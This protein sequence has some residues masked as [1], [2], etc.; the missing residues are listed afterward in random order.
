MKFQI[1]EGY[2][3]WIYPPPPPRFP[4]EKSR[5]ILTSTYAR[6]AKAAPSAFPPHKDVRYERA[7]RSDPPRGLS[8][9]FPFCT[10]SGLFTSNK[11]KS[12][13]NRRVIRLGTYGE[14]AFTV[15]FHNVGNNI[16]VQHAF[17]NIVSQRQCVV[18]STAVTV[19]RVPLWTFNERA[20]KTVRMSVPRSVRAGGGRRFTTISG[21]GFT[22]AVCRIV[23]RRPA[24][25]ELHGV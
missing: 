2:I 16:D 25:S 24:V 6:L 19:N 8:R 9:T 17:C 4:P 11:H 14:S 23:V 10:S 12:L 3:Y 15:C 7:R 21:R 20:A 13:F 18:T 5:R 22:T 1:S